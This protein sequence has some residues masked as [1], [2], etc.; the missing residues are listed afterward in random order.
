M[1]QRASLAPFNT[2]PILRLARGARLAVMRK[3]HQW[4]QPL[5][6]IGM[7]LLADGLASGKER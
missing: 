3:P 1:T 4:E 7:N 2:T 5:L 6:V